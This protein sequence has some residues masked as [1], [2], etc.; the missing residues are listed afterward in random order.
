M[1]ELSLGSRIQVP[2]TYKLQNESEA[3]EETTPEEAPKEEIPSEEE[4]VPETA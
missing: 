2:M 4:S 3:V 1:K